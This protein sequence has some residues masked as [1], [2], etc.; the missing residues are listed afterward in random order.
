MQT[1]ESNEQFSCIEASSPF[2]EL[3]IFAE[4]VEKFSPIT[5]I[6]YEVQF[7]LC[8]ESIVQVYNKGILYFLKDL[9]LS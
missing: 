1:I 7:I 2:W 5:E 6:H 3:N 8:L 9:T 4:V